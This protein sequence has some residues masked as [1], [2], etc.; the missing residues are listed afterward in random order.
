MGSTRDLHPCSFTPFE[1]D[2]DLTPPSQGD[3][4][5]PRVQSP[6]A[7]TTDDVQATSDNSD[8]ET[9]TDDSDADTDSPAHSP[10][11]SPQSSS[12]ARVYEM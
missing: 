1:L 7:K 10:I 9:P 12:D 8:S 2:S 6:A 4:K 3:S 5:K 11:G